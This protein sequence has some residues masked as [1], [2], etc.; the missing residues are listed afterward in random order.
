[1]LRDGGG[2]SAPLTGELWNDR[3]PLAVCAE[4][5]QAL[6]PM[7]WWER[8]EGWCNECCQGGPD[9]A[10]SRNV[11]GKQARLTGTVSIFPCGGVGGRTGDSERGSSCTEIDTVSIVSANQ[12]AFSMVKVALCVWY[13]PARRRESRTMARVKAAHRIETQW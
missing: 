5:V 3:P 4:A 8:R 12:S 2:A 6:G 7:G 11:P 9:G 1:M 10:V 13:E